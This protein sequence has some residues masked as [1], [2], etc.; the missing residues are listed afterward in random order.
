MLPVV[1]PGTR[2]LT[3]FVKLGWILVSECK[4]EQRSFRVSHITTVKVV[5]GMVRAAK[6]H[7]GP[8]WEEIAA[9]GCAVQVLLQASKQSLILFNIVIITYM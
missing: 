1:S 9:V 8:E 5:L 3:R 7:K 2:D 6:G 4:R